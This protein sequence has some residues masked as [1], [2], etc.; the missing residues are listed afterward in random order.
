MSKN[1]VSL[2]NVDLIKG[3]LKHLRMLKEEVDKTDEFALKFSIYFAIIGLE[4]VVRCL[5]RLGESRE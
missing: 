3:T 1:I 2:A 4:S 5:E